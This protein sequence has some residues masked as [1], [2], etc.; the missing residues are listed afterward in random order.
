M[1]SRADLKARARFTMKANY[2]K[3]VLVSFV[4]LL[5]GGNFSSNFNVNTKNS[6]ETVYS[7]YIGDPT[8]INTPFGSFAV[9]TLLIISLILLAIGV[10]I[11]VFLCNPL[12]VGC[13]RFF[14]INL[15]EPAYA[16]NMGYAFK[17][18]YGNIVGIMFQKTVYTF[19]WT[20]LLIIPGIIKHYEYLMI[21]Y[22][23]AENPTL[24]EQEA[25][26]MSKQMMDGQKLNAFILDLSFIGW[27]ILSS[28]TL[29]LLG[30]FYVYPYINSTHA[31]L[32][33]ALR[34]GRSEF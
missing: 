6:Y 11:T 14:M 17:N 29:G 13:D 2:W 1:W 22:L 5:V 31:A 10:A 9:G 20:L 7:E 32:F 30:I 15:H 8:I 21:P 19:F 25:F 3:C 26:E 23:L 33:E 12:I 4:F 16:G 34:F 28:I 18:N 24:S 27:Y